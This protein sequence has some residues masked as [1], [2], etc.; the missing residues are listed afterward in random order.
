MVNVLRRFWRYLGSDGGSVPYGVLFATLG[1]VGIVVA[2]LA[3]GPASVRFG[4]AAELLWV[5][6]LVSVWRRVRARLLLTSGIGWLAAMVISTTGTPTELA[7]PIGLSV[8]AGIALMWSL[9]TRTEVSVTWAPG[10]VYNRDDGPKP[11]METVVLVG[12]GVLLVI[13]IGLLIWG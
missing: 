5:L 11:P 10:K 1:V 3:D 12:T 6:G 9:A 4:Y 2:V 8:G 7:V 13:G